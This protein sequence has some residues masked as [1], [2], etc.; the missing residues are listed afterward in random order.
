MASPYRRRQLGKVSPIELP[1]KQMA[2]IALTTDQ[3]DDEG[4]VQLVETVVSGAVITHQPAEV[5]VFKIDNWFD[6]KW[7]GFSGKEMGAFG[8]WCTKTT[9][10]PFVANRIIGQL[11]YEHHAEDE[12]YRL[13]VPAPDIHHRGS[14]ID[15]FRRTVDCV[16]PHSALVW[17]S[18][19]TL[20]MGR[21]SLMCY[22]PIERKIW[23]WYL[24]FVR[25]GGWRINRRKL[26]HEYEVR[27][28]QS[29]GEGM[30][31]SRLA[32]H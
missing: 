12:P 31:A 32:G 17:Y 21:G 28:F 20:K 1:D 9:I 16:A 6:H 22:M 18:G 30:A 5:R 2:M 24:S 26:I 4:F 3:S 29:S 25:D 11:R 13:S 27:L 10:P 14:A 23:T 15:N 19:N 7:L 8:V